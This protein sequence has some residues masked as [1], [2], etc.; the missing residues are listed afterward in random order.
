MQRLDVNSIEIDHE[1]TT[2]FDGR[3][4][5]TLKFPA[6]D[7]AGINHAIATSY[8]F[9]YILTKVHHGPSFIVR[10]KFIRDESEHARQRADW[11]MSCIQSNGAWAPPSVVFPMPADLEPRIDALAAARARRSLV[12]V[13]DRT[14]ALRYSLGEAGLLGLIAWLFRDSGVVA[15]ALLVLAALTLATWAVSPIFTRAKR[16]GNEAAIQRFDQQQNIERGFVG[17]P[18]T[19][20]GGRG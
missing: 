10:L 7:S 1:T 19:A 5:A 4:A 18:P 15:Q 13:Q 3:P 14:S 11:S 9:G 6:F 16:R 2:Q 17:P 20:S 8:E 12:L